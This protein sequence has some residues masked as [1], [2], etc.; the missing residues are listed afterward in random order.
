ME[1]KEMCTIIDDENKKKGP[2]E[3]LYLICVAGLGDNPNDWVIVEGRTEAYEYIK[4]MIEEID[5][6]RSFILVETEKLNTRKSIYAFM[7]YVE[8]F[9]EGDSF[10]IDDYVR[11][12]WSE[13]DFQEDNNISPE[14]INN[15]K[16]D[17]K[18]MMNGDTIIKNEGDD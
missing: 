9:Y 7:K 5:I 12:D 3:K 15:N 11:G 6:S 2:E 4:D 10:D 14:F 8:R 17:I 18:D 16:F 13:S 1:L